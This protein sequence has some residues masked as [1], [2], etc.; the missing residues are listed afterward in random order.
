VIAH[1]K[2]LEPEFLRGRWFEIGDFGTLLQPLEAT[3]PSS[4]MQ[5]RR[6]LEQLQKAFHELL[7]TDDPPRGDGE[8]PVLLDVQMT[9]VL[10]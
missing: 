2:R 3:K 5:G 10:G 4:I 1:G 6:F 8:V 9:N 7:G